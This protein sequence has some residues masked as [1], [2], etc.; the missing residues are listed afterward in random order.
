MSQTQAD[1]AAGQPEPVAELA[2][3]LPVPPSVNHQYASVNG[4]R[5]LSRAGR[6]FKALVADEVEEWRDREGISNETL[7]LFGRHYL[8]LTITFYFTSA[9]RRDLDG[10]LKIAQDALCEAL[11]V[12]DNLVVEIHLRK[13]IDRQSPR[14]DVVLQALPEVVLHEELGTALTLPDFPIAPSKRRRKRRKQRSL[15]ELTTRFNWE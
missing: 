9:L 15:E 10:G 13:R 11:G 12:N 1:Q 6:D 7:A 14:I 3:V 4:R 8:S 5:V 2:L